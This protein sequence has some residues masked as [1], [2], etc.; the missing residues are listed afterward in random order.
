MPIASYCVVLSLVGFKQFSSGLAFCRQDV[1]LCFLKRPT[2]AFGMFHWRRGF[3][4]DIML[5]K[6]ERTR[7][8]QV[9]KKGKK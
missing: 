4:A 3:S 2:I 6:N 7:V 9:P 5:H 1:K 8:A